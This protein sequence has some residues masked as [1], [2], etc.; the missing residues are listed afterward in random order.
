ME[1]LDEAIGAFL[2]VLRSSWATVRAS[3]V[4][5]AGWDGSVLSDWAQ[6][7]WEMIVEAALSRGDAVAL[8]VYGDGADCNEGSSRVWKPSALP[9]HAVACLPRA[10]AVKD[11]LTGQEVHF[12][13]GGLPLSEFVTMAGGD[14]WYEVKPPFDS[15]LLV[16]GGE[17]VVVRISGLS[18]SLLPAEPPSAR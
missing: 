5:S 18:F 12:P 15:V 14:G 6:A 10:T 7:N 13:P 2:T 1:S 8:E 17:D 4:E 11:Q 9:T 3:L 16:V